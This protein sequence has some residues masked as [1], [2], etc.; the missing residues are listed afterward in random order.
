MSG[1]SLLALPLAGVMVWSVIGSALADPCPPPAPVCRPA[2]PPAPV[3]PPACF[4]AP[5]R[6]SVGPGELPELQP[7]PTRHTLTICNGTQV[8]Q[9]NFIE[10]HGSWRNCR[11]F[12]NYDVFFRDSPRV[13]WRYYGTYYSARR[14]EEAAGI[15]RANGNLASVRPHRA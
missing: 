4:A 6:P 5:A 7:P 2:C 1:K 12:K 10:R 9:Q 3:C 14:A 11:E 8:V 13:P 15:L